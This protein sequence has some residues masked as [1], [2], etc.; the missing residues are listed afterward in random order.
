MSCALQGLLYRTKTITTEHL[1]AA[2][3]VRKKLNSTSSRVRAD[4]RS[5]AC[6]ALK[7]SVPP[8]QAAL[9]ID[10]IKFWVMRR[11]HFTEWVGKIEHKF[12]GAKL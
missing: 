2:F 12:A 6:F 4:Q 9:A 3:I 11:T 8:S 10:I 7:P 5:T 1:T